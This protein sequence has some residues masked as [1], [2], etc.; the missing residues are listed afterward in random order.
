MVAGL[1]FS[2]SREFLDYGGPEAQWPIAIVGGRYLDFFASL[3]MELSEED[4]GEWMSLR[5]YLAH[6]GDFR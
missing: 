4:T 5:E 2:S 6:C 1:G 3:S